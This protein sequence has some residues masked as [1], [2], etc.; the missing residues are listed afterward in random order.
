M[1]L[2]VQGSSIL[3]TDILINFKQNIVF[4]HLEFGMLLWTIQ[5]YINLFFVKYNKI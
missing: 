2:P 1:V 5:F 3:L 4:F